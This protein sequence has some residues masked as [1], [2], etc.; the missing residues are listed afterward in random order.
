MAEAM[1]GLVHTARYI[2]LPI[3]LLYGRR[4]IAC[5]YSSVVGE[6]EELSLLAGG[7]GVV[8]DRQLDMLNFCR[9]SEVY[10]SYSRRMSP[11]ACLRIS[12]PSKNL[13]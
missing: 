11:S 1:S 9:T 12:M 5:F 7:R 4:S 13:T 8:A 2:R 3:A 10:F 6:S